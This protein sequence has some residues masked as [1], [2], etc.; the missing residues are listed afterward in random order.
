MPYL[1][2][3]GYEERFGA[4]EL[5][6][7]LSTDDSLTLARAI[8][9][10]QSIVDGYLAAVPARAFAVPLVSTPARISEITADLTRYELHAKKV[11]HEIKRR[12]E[13][14]I[15][16]LEALVAGKQA[17]PELLPDAGAPAT[18]VSGAEAFAEPRVFTTDSL[19][20]YL[21]R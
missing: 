5:E 4:A 20:G 17:I 11:T 7:V 18:L 19:T 2:Q 15:A 10:A 14:A 16:F 21:G 3:T 9:D 12:R 8:A 13:Q 6:Q 1:D